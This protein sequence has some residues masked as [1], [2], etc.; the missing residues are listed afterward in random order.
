MNFWSRKHKTKIRFSGRCKSFDIL[1]L[2]VQYHFTPFVLE[3]SLDNLEWAFWHDI[4][5]F[6]FATWRFLT[7]KSYSGL[8]VAL[9]PLGKTSF[10]T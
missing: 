10:Q 2:L 7:D 4:S 8:D 9:Q 3:R 5:H 1:S 6:Q